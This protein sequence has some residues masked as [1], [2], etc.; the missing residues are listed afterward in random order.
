[1]KKVLTI[2]IFLSLVLWLLL[3]SAQAD[4]NC[5]ISYPTDGPILQELVFTCT[6]N[7]AGG[8]YSSLTTRRDIHGI[9][10]MAISDPGTA[11]ST[12][13]WDFTL[14]E[15]GAD[16]L[17]GQGSNRDTANTERIFPRDYS[18]GTVGGVPVNGPLT[19]NISGNSQ[20]SA[21]V[22]IRFYGIFE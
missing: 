12:D 17:G 1:M 16:I 5:V 9:I 8:T 6:A 10:L 20:A 15:D 3:L 19:L 22:V 4:D 11:T 18:G 13:N 14:T 2:L 21:E 7:A